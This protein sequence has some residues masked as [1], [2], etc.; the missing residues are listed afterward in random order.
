MKEVFRTSLLSEVYGLQAALLA[1]G[2]PSTV[3][4]EHSLGMVAG[5][6]RL[7][8]EDEADVERAAA[9]LADYSRQTTADS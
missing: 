6:L 5:E 9:I 7:V 1:A 3:L 8:L 4:G 2:I